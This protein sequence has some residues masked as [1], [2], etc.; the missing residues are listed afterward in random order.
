MNIQNC[1]DAR[2]LFLI[3]EKLV[4]Q[5]SE[6]FFNTWLKIAGKRSKEIST[7]SWEEVIAMR[8]RSIPIV[9]LKYNFAEKSSSSSIEYHDSENE[10]DK[11]ICPYQHE[12][13]KRSI[14]TMASYTP[15]SVAIQ[16]RKNTPD[17]FEK[18]V[19]QKLVEA[20]VKRLNF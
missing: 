16:V 7:P 8:D 2:I 14:F 15:Q 13:V 10:E 12:T 19:L 17:I 1:I 9:A 20:Y 11:Y 5:F 6:N 18:K 3:I 4:I